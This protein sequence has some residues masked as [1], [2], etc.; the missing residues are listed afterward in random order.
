MGLLATCSQIALGCGYRRKL[1]KQIDND[2][3][4]TLLVT[5]RPNEIKGST[6]LRQSPRTCADPKVGRIGHIG[7][8]I[9]AQTLQS[10]LVGDDPG[11]AQQSRQEADTTVIAVELALTVSEVYQCNAHRSPSARGTCL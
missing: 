1:G 7:R 5:N 4:M 9:P 3:K 8:G 11:L 10:P 2:L 6:P